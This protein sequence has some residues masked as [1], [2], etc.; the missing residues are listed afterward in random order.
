MGWQE[1]YGGT[2]DV[3]NPLD[4]YPMKKKGEEQAAS[5]NWWQQPATSAPPPDIAPLSMPQQGMEQQDVPPGWGF[6][7]AY[8]GK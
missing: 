4:A 2:D 6:L 7:R 1:L 5:K 3:Q 8:L